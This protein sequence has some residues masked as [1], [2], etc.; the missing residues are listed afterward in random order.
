MRRYIWD[1]IRILEELGIFLSADEY[2]R[3]WSLQKESEIDAYTHRLIMEKEPV[4]FEFE[5]DDDLYNKQFSQKLHI[6]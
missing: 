3:L 5:D 4:D 1:K 6:L 2:S